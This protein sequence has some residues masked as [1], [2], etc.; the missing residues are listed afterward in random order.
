[1]E[2]KGSILYQHFESI[3][4]NFNILIDFTILRV[5]AVVLVHMFFSVQTKWLESGK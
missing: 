5:R 2:V 1:M 3:V 4:Q